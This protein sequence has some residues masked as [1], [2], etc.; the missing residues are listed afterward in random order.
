LSCQADGYQLGT[1]EASVGVI[2]LPIPEEKVKTRSKAVLILGILRKREEKRVD[3]P[4]NNG[5]GKVTRNHKA[6]EKQ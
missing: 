1:L 5:S 3:W 2:L 6:S 4:I